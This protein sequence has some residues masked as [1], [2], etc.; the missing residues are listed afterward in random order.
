MLAISATNEDREN[1]ERL[2]VKFG[3]LHGDRPNVS[4]LIRAIASGDLILTP[5]ASIVSPVVS[6]RRPLPSRRPRLS[7]P[8]QSPRRRSS[9]R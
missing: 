5:L 1:L 9:P 4:A 3:C 7:L 2:A 6:V 8:Q